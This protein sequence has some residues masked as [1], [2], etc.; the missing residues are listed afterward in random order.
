MSSSETAMPRIFC[1]IPARAG[2]KGVPDKNIQKIGGKTLTR[3]AVEFCLDTDV[4]DKIILSSD[5]DAILA[6]ASDL[7]VTLDKRPQEFAS[8]EALVADAIFEYFTS[9][10]NVA[11]PI[12]DDWIVIMEPSSPLRSQKHFKVAIDKMLSDKYDTVLSV[13]ESTSVFWV[14]Y[15]DTWEMKDRKAYASQRQSRAKQYLEAN[16]FF[17]FRWKTLLETRAIHGVRTNC[18]VV[19][20]EEAVDI[21]SPLDLAWAQF[22][23]EGILRDPDG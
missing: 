13:V 12:A 3:L 21:N 18:I 2:S 16:C 23:A 1:F 14:Q 7:P 10:R 8:D 22:L 5:G 19:P 6:E 17:C 4:F 20:A 15:N 9:T 11:E